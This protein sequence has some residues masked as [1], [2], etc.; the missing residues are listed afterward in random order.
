LVKD[1][2]TSAN[3]ERLKEYFEG[4]SLY[5]LDEAQE[6][7]LIEEYDGKLEGYEMK[8][9]PQKSY[10]APSE[11]KAAYPESPVTCISKDTYFEFLT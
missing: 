3:P 5:I 4:L 10:S 9:S 6:I 1:L 7:D 11:W 8:F 2:L